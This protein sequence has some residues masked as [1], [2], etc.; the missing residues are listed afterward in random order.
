[1]WEL[2]INFSVTIFIGCFLLLLCWSLKRYFERKHFMKRI[3]RK[4]TGIKVKYWMGEIAYHDGV[5]YGYDESG[6]V[7]INTFYNGQ[8]K[9]YP[10][11]INP[12]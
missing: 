2:I 12:K 10:K 3:Y 9:K 8:I 4:E 6:R 5:V 7:I 1:M 11:Y